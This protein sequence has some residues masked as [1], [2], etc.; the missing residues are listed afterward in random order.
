LYCHER[1]MDDHIMLDNAHEVVLTNLKSYQPH[2]CTCL[3]IEA[4]LP[5]ANFI[6]LKQANH[7]LI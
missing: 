2:K 5:C 4:I 6:A 3:Q 1:F 7:P